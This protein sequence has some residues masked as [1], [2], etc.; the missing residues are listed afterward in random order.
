MAMDKF[1]NKGLIV[2]RIGF[3]GGRFNPIHY[4]H[5][6]LAQTALEVL[7]LD[8]VIFMPSGGQA[9]YK[10]EDDVV[11]GIRRLD[12]VRLA[13]ASNPCFEASSYE[14]DRKE[15]CYTIDTLRQLRDRQLVGNEIYLLVG[16]DWLN[17]ITHWKEG[18]KLLQEFN[19]AV[20]SR[21]GEENTPRTGTI[22]QAKNIQYIPMPLIDISSS[23][24]RERVGKGLPI[25]YLTPEPV[26][27]YIEE[28][29]LYKG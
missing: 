6:N 10:T 7:Q 26:C 3:Y 17:K 24:I 12:M 19:V 4:A 25:Q 23:L 8:R 1:G 20:F 28:R 11:P 9:C 27:R 15:F 21:P 14:V 5:L 29:E 18:D 16:G 22:T 2:K 13:I